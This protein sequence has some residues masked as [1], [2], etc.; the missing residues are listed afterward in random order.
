MNNNSY[1]VFGS[2]LSGNCYKVALILR[3]TGKPCDW[4]ETDV[5]A[6]ATRTAEFLAMNPVGKVPVLRLPDGRILSE[7]NAM[8][9]FL[10]ENT[11]YLPEDRYQRALVYQWLFY[12][13]YSHEPYIAVA[14]FLLKYEH[15]QAVDPE[16]MSSL[17]KRGCTAF[18]VMD[19]HLETQLFF[20]GADFTIA[21]MALY[22]YSHVAGDGGFDT[23]RWPAVSAWLKRVSGQE[24]VFDINDMQT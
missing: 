1:T 10:A 19:A 14:R 4:I 15:G 24:G 23:S 17:Y 20:A 7:S 13:Q 18:D 5:L 11:R 2:S 12:E 22:A 16:R 21:D 3:L 9:I 6:G 8:L